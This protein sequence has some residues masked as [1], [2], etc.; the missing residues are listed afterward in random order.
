ME[1]K[2]IWHISPEKTVIRKEDISGLT[3]DQLLVRADYSMISIGTERNVALG[4]VPEG[5]YKTME[6][7]YMLG[8]FRFPLTF[9]YSLTGEVI[10]GPHDL[11]GKKVHL[12]HP[13]QDYAIV[14]VRDIFVVPEIIHPAYASLASNLE[15][16]VNAVWDSRI[17]IGDRALIAGFGSVG[18][19][20]A[21][22]LKIAIPG[23]RL[24]I[25]EKS[26]S[27]LAAGKAAGFDM[28]EELKERDGSFDVSFDTTGTE[29]GLQTC[30]DH[31]GYEG[32]MILLSW[33][34]IS[35]TKL[36][37]GGDFHPMRKKIISSQVSNIPSHQRARWDFYRRKQLVFEILKSKFWDR[38]PLNIIAFEEA[39]DFFNR[40]R[41][42]EEEH[43]F[44]L[45]KYN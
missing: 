9:G 25:L 38:I 27:R 29:K 19:L 36:N 41:N 34:G 31:L 1:I 21:A 4:R 15:T 3:E 7:P 11:R 40:L 37:L 28:V 43:I 10:E 6:V 13:H 8:T 44:N 22:T 23:V 17:T 24:T 33:F 39:P 32:K 14:E 16:A 42:N 26:S 45:I 5:L 12:L 2:A 18:A 20:L 30:I 35:Q